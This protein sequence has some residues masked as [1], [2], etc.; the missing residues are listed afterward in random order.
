MGRAQA[1]VQAAAF[2]LFPRVQAIPFLLF[3]R[4]RERFPFLRVRSLFPCFFPASG[5]LGD[6][7]HAMATPRRY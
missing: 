1:Q 4:A 5:L 7:F 6:A 2:L 3:P